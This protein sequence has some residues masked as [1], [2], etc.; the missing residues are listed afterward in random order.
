[1]YGQYPTEKR[2]LQIRAQRGH[3]VPR[4]DAD[5]D[6]DVEGFQV[7]G[8]RGDG[9]QAAVPCGEVCEGGCDAEV[10]M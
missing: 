7:R 5:L 6:K 2:T 1:M 3:E 8:E 4:V 10:F 9:H